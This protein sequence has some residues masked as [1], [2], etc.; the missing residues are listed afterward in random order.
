[1]IWPSLAQGL[2]ATGPLLG[3]AVGLG[4]GVGLGLDEG[5]GVPVGV[6]AGGVGLADGSGVAVTSSADCAGLPV[7][8]SVGATL[9][10][11]AAEPVGAPW[12]TLGGTVAGDG[13]ID[14]HEIARTLRVAMV[15]LNRAATRSPDGIPTSVRPNHRQGVPERD[16]QADPATMLALASDRQC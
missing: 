1:M 10:A 3:A 9:P 12:L 16:G 7:A 4:V 14:P 5:A 15:S 2:V 8:G 6:G 13:W 11:A